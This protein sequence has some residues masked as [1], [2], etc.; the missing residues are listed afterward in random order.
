MLSGTVATLT[1]DEVSFAFHMIYVVITHLKPVVPWPLWKVFPSRTP[2]VSSDVKVKM[3]MTAELSSLAYQE[4]PAPSAPE[5]QSVLAMSVNPES[6]VDG[7]AMTL[8]EFRGTGTNDDENGVAPDENGTLGLLVSLTV[9]EVL[10][11]KDVR[12]DPAKNIDAADELVV[13]ELTLPCAP[14]RPLNGAADHD[15]AF[16]SHTATE[17]PGEENLPP[18]HTLDSFVSQNTACTA[19]FGP[20]DPSAAKAPD[21]GL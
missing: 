5:G 15:D 2:I 16:V 4:L 11:V 10:P 17:E 13:I 8:E 1:R 6:V 20:L 21:E 18:N 3:S 12:K 14:T 19:P 9:V 7:L